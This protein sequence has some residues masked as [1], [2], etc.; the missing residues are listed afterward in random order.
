VG[1]AQQVVGI[2]HPHAVFEA[3]VDVLDLGRDES[4][5]LRSLPDRDVISDQAPT[6]SH[7]LD[8]IGNGAPH[9]S[10]QPL[11]HRLDA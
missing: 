11:G 4:E 2:G 10:T 3:Q 8:G 5:V 1:A 7:T 9:H 6:R